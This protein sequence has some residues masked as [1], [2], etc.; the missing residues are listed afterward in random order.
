MVYMHVQVYTEVMLK[1]ASA[2]TAWSLFSCRVGEPYYYLLFKVSFLLVCF[3][4][5]QNMMQKLIFLLWKINAIVTRKRQGEP[6]E[7]K[8]IC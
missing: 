1:Y 3:Q 5:I 2:E 4:I 8:T 6:R 7:T